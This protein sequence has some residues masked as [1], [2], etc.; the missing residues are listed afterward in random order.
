MSRR[1]YDTEFKKEASR[2][3]IEEG[4]TI[5]SVEEAL[6]ITRG[7]LKDWVQLYRKHSDAAFVGSGNL[8]PEDEKVRRLEKQ[9][10]QV[11]RERDILKKAVAIFSKEPEINTGS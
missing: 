10:Q 1:K 8:L 5:R 11:T 2:L 6:G 3:V 4:R 7:V 9:L